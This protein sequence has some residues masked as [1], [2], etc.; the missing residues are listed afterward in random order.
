MAEPEGDS[1]HDDDKNGHDEPSL[2]GPR[3]PPVAD[4][5]GPEPRPLGFGFL[6]HTV[7]SFLIF[8]I[9]SVSRTWSEGVA[10]I[11]RYLVHDVIK[12]VT[13]RFVIG[14]KRSLP[15]AANRKKK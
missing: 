15:S 3:T 2:P 11:Q 9:L 7:T 13:P 12:A 1:N 5:M 14:L 6:S 8:E 4:A 10:K